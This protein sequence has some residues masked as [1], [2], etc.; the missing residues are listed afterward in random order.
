MLGFLILKS[1]PNVE[2]NVLLG[3]KILSSSAKLTTYFSSVFT[4]FVTLTE[5]AADSV[6]TQETLP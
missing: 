5:V 1:R 4:A 3:Q 2:S 6:D